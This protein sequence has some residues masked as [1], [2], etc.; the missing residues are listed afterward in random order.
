MRRKTFLATLPVV[1]LSTVP[2][3]ALAQT[4]PK[5]KI[6]MTFPLTGP[7]ASAASQYIPGAQLAIEAV[8]R[9]GGVKGRQLELVVEDSQATPQGGI[10]AMRKLVEVDGVQAVITIFTNVVVAQ[11]P[12]ADQLKVPCLSNIVTAGLVSKSQYSFVHQVTLESVAPLIAR[13]WRAH[14]VK[15][16]YGVFS[17]NAFGQQYLPVARAMAQQAG[18]D[19]SVGY[20]DLSASDYRGVAIRAKDYNP[21]ALLIAAQGGQAETTAIRQLREL[22]VTA[23]MYDPAV[24]Y[25]LKSWRQGVGAYSEGMFF[26]GVAVPERIAHDFIVAYRSKMGFDPDYNA[27]QEYDMVQ[28]YAAAIAKGGYSGEAIRNALA[29]STGVPSVFGGTITMGADHYTVTSSVGLFQ[30]R[31]GHLVQVDGSAV[32]RT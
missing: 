2:T 30:V 29:S 10:A 1:G 28:L 27:A 6:G 31:G 8:N 13:H 17:D 21:D 15:R 20:L 26:A 19:L 16:V 5:Y 23:P 9:A 25:Q 11:M 22:G 18:A 14:N 4:S 32:K 24:F 12:L 7:L 3:L